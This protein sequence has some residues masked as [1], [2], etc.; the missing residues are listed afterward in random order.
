MTTAA[1]A[2]TNSGTEFAAW[3]GE[4]APKE[5]RTFWACFCGWALDALDVQIF[6]F[7]I[8]AGLR[9]LESDIRRVAKRNTAAWSVDG[10]VRGQRLW[11]GRHRRSPTARDEGPR[12][13]RRRLT[14][15][16]H[17]GRKG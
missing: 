11:A 4:L 5:K 6:S 8:P 12:V 3:Y 14:I 9:R 17:G 2:K 13:D 1:M 15:R 7:A 16:S 10:S